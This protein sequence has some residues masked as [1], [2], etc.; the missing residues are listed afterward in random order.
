MGLASH[1]FFRLP[2]VFV[3]ATGAVVGLAFLVVRFNPLIVYSSPYA[4]WRYVMILLRSV[5]TAFY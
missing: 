3:I 2:I 1:L 4:V 5:I